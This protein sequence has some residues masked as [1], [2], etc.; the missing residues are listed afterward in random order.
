[1]IIHRKDAK[2]AKKNMIF[3]WGKNLCALCAFAV[4]NSILGIIHCFLKAERKIYAHGGMP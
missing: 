1:M 2:D 3:L 4:R